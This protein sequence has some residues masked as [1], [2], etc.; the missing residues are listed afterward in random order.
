[1]LAVLD[2]LA[3]IPDLDVARIKIRLKEG[4]SGGW[5]D[6]MYVVYGLACALTC[7]GCSRV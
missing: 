7:R 6:L 1:M 3:S 2:A 4:T 5:K